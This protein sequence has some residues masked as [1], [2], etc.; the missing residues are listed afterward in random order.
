MGVVF[1]PKKTHSLEIILHRFKTSFLCG[2]TTSYLF[3]PV[4]LSKQFLP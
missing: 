2:F 4:I 3:K 1:F